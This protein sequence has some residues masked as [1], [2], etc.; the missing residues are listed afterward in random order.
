[1]RID[2]E[3]LR[4]VISWKDV[5]GWPVHRSHGPTQYVLVRDLAAK[6]GTL[7]SI[8]GD[9]GRQ[10][11]VGDGPW[12]WHSYGRYGFLKPCRGRRPPPR[13]PLRVTGW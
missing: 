11:P 13:P 10:G 9:S 5:D 7:E 3:K 12:P 4:L 8:Q 2:P 1:V 6:Q